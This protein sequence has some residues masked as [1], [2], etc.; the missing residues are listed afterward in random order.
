MDKLDEL[1]IENV[2]TE[3]S[4]VAI[5]K[6]SL[7]NF[8]KR[9]SCANLLQIFQN[10]IAVHVFVTN[11]DWLLPEEILQNPQSKNITLFWDLNTSNPSINSLNFRTSIKKSLVEPHNNGT[12][13]TGFIFMNESYFCRSLSGFQPPLHFSTQIQVFEVSDLKNCKPRI[14]DINKSTVKDYGDCNEDSV[15]LEPGKSNRVAAYSQYKK[16]FK[17]LNIQTG[18]QLMLIQFTHNLFYRS[19]FTTWQMYD[20]N[21]SLGRFVFLQEVPNLESTKKSFQFIV[22]TEEK[23]RSGHL[24]DLPNLLIGN[25]IE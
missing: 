18:E 1:P 6:V 7:I 8:L 21:W 25:S 19:L 5:V 17:I 2:H 22:V 11:L 20:A 23:N 9:K 12:C 14:I 3:I 4:D 15:N 24:K 16:N 10:C 13:D